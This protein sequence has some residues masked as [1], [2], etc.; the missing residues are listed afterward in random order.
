MNL[1]VIKLKEEDEVSTF[2]SASLEKLHALTE[3]FGGQ[4]TQHP[5][6]SFQHPASSTL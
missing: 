5:A 2:A 3:I 4:S 1:S 6:P